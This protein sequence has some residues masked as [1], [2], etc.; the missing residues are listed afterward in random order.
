MTDAPQSLTDFAAE[1]PRY[2]N[3]EAWITTLPEW[4]E[5]LEAWQAGKV[6]QGQIHDWLIQEK[7]Y[8][9]AQVTRAKIA[10]LSKVYPRRARG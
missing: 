7:G 3:S 5:I 10:H 2:S 9:K 6:N 4:P 1:N 8:P